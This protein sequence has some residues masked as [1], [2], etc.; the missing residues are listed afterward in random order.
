MVKNH[1]EIQSKI[2]KKHKSMDVKCWKIR[3]LYLL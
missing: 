1:I 3:L 2:M